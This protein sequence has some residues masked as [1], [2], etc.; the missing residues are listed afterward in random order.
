[1]LRRAFPAACVLVVAMWPGAALAQ[2][3][4]GPQP[5][6]QVVL[7]GD[8]VVPRG[9]VVGEVVVFDGT[10]LVGGVVR[11]DVVV[12]NGS[13]T[14]SGQVA[15]DVIAVHGTI[16]LLPT[17]QVA[18]TVRGGS[19]VVVAA[20][21]QVGG[22]IA[23]GV[24]FSLSGPVAALG[25]LLAAAAVAVSVLVVALLLWWL[26]PRGVERVAS[27]G[28][29]H[30]LAAGGWGMALALGLPILAVATAATILGLPIGLSLLLA[31]GLLWLLGLAA[32][33]WVVG[34][35]LVREPRRAG[36]AL[37]AGWGVGTAV[38]LVPV[39]NVVWWTLGGIFGVGVLLVATWRARR[40][41]TSAAPGFGDGGRAGRHRR[42]RIP[43]VPVA[44][45]PAAA[46]ADASSAPPETPLAED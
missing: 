26:A 31:T 42:G 36:G 15:G 9:Q 3:R 29:E 37:A 24:R 14:I 35:A 23:R 7:R 43:P 27:V 8:V 6:D 16:R 13:V 38:G 39:L 41:A 10:V 11:G 18:G 12:L 4:S 22:G 1:M 40:I 34:R 2:A 19:D 32:A 45:A 30:P 46:V 25:A 21:A 20:G 5:S 28:R 44:P 17:A 33:T